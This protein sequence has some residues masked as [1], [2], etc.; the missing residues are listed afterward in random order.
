M[1]FSL[2]GNNIAAGFFYFVLPIVALIRA[3]LRPSEVMGSKEI[4]Q[5]LSKKERSLK[6]G[7][8]F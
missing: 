7:F 2:T 4:S 8:N 5:F 6:K 1:N 3:E